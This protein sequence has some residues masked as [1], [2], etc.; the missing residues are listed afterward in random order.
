MINNFLTCIR[1]GTLLKE[2]LCYFMY[3]FKI[4]NKGMLGKVKVN[5]VYNKIIKKYNKKKLITLFNFE[6]KKKVDFRNVVWIFWY[7]GMSNAPEIVKKCYNSVLSNFKDKEVILITKD[8]FLD[9]IDIPNFIIDRVDNKQ[10]S[11]THFSDILRLA[12]LITYGGLWLDATVFCTDN[13]DYNYI[14][15]LDF[16]VYRDGW[17][18]NQTIKI[19]NWLIWSKPDNP[20]LKDTLILLYNYWKKEKYAC[21]YFIFHL[22]FNISIEK[23]RELWEKVPYINHIDNHLLI[24]DIFK[25]FNNNRF[26]FICKHTDF[27]KLTYKLDFSKVTDTSFLNYIINRKL[28]EKNE[29]I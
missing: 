3:K 23:H 7:Q 4:I 10:M 19:A 6:K 26:S 20:I 5:I 8:N 11:I 12:L 28:E 1:N 15:S 18:D 9:Y 21:N 14:S 24:N 25:D 17:F 2:S 27:H 16:F 29:N 13:Q 22:F